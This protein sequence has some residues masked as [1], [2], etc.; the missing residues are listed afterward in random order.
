MT[1]LISTILSHQQIFGPNFWIRNI[2]NVDVL[3]LDIIFYNWCHMNRT[4]NS[5]GIEGYRVKIKSFLPWPVF[6]N[7]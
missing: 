4:Q 6:P 2:V 7:S 3:H 1:T 5:K